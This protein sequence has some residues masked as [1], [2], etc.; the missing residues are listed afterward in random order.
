MTASTTL[1]NEELQR[2]IKSVY[3]YIKVNENARVQRG[4]ILIK[5]M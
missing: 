4:K 5:T 3:F 2:S 1:I